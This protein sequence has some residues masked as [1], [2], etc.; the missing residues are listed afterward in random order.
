MSE[1]KPSPAL[2]AMRDLDTLAASMKDFDQR[3]AA[4]LDAIEAVYGPLPKPRDKIT[5]GELRQ[6][7]RRPQDRQDAPGPR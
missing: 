3:T 4:F 5:V 2:R 7:C 1:P 6:H